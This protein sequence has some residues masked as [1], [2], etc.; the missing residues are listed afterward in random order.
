MMNVWMIS[1]EMAP[2]SKVGGLG[3]VV[4]ALPGALSKLGVKTTVFVPH[5]PEM[6]SGKWAITDTGIEITL[7][8]GVGEVTAR[9]L[10]TT[11]GPDAVRVVF[12]NCPQFFHREG[13]YGT[14]DG[15]YWDNAQR[16]AFF[17]RAAIE[18]GRRL[19]PGPDVIHAHDWPAALSLFYARAP[20]HYG[21]MA[22][23]KNAALV[24]SI[25]NLSYQGRFHKE[26]LPEL[27]IGWHRF[28]FLELEFWDAINFL[29]AG[30]VYSDAIVAVSPSYAHE[31]QSPENG[32]GLD[33]LLRER[34]DCLHGILNGIDTQL[35]DPAKD[36]ALEATFTSNRLAPRIK[37][38]AALRA[39]FGLPQTDAPLVGIVTRF[40]FQKGI[41]ILLELW[42]RL[43]HLG[44]QLALLGTGE[45]RY[46]DELTQMARSMPEIVGLKVGFSDELARR[47]YGGSD[48]FM[49][50][51]LFEPCGL[52][53]LIALRYGAV[54]VVRRTG[55]LSDTVKDFG[56]PDGD[57]VVFDHPT[58]DDAAHALWRATELY[59]DADN[60]IAVRK[61]GM[62]RDNSWKASAAKYAELYGS[63]KEEKRRGDKT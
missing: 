50:P 56:L 22:D 2:F 52:G 47:I 26:L 29:K 9:V 49:M 31:I 59:R 1:P 4:G 61:R 12:I 24:Q 38:K 25:H 42:Q 60:F 3:D 5:L 28:N 51:S 30:I 16:F 48:F 45:K 43:P 32:W 55:G 23:I 27:G 39:F 41:D 36:K 44:V 40:V 35:F 15:E 7:P 34:R 13:I 18:A 33:G 46:E 10:E 54:P 14:P 20:E 11:L 63:L 53:Q 37:N 17:S 62:A 57:G 21:E 58:A 6:E 19:A 8:S